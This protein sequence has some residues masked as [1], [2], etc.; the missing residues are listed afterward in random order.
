MSDVKAKPVERNV[1]M[2]KGCTECHQNS[3]F[4]LWDKAGNTW[5]SCSNKI[6][7]SY[8]TGRPPDDAVRVDGKTPT[9]APEGSASASPGAP[10]GGSSADILDKIADC[11]SELS[12]H[13]AE[14]AYLQK[15]RS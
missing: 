5:Y 8:C 15:A 11:F 9:T 14:L 12:T 13:F 7:S 1:V 10:S 3:N 4:T 6:G 2:D